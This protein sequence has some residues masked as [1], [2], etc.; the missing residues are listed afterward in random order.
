M[1]GKIVVLSTL[2]LIAVICLL[3]FFL[4]RSTGLKSTYPK[5]VRVAANEWDDLSFSEE[6]LYMGKM[7]LKIQCAPC[8]GYDG[9]GTK[10][11][12]S[13]VAFSHLP[14]SE[15]ILKVENGNPQN[16]MPAWINKIQESDII[17]VAAYIKYQLSLDEQP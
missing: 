5:P 13:L 3:F 1:K 14:L 16:G 12:P 15:I 7:V 4:I 2:L 17:N 8:H 11:A 9:L 6:S 10:T